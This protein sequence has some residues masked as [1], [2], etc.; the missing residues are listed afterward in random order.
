[1]TDC[2]TTVDSV[3]ALLNPTGSAGVAAQYRRVAPPSTAAAAASDAAR[4]R[5]TTPPSAAEAPPPPPHS[6]QLQFGESRGRRRVWDSENGRSATVH[7]C[8][9]MGAASLCTKTQKLVL[10]PC[11]QQWVLCPCAGQRVL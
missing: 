9:I 8:T 3:L 6:A 4:A 1:M 5:G 2:D 7:N 10:R 11:V